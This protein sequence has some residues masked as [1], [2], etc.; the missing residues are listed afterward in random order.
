MIL[1]PLATTADGYK[2]PRIFLFH[3]IDKLTVRAKLSSVICEFIFY[4]FPGKS[5]IFLKSYKWYQVITMIVR[6][7]M[8]P[9]LECTSLYAFLLYMTML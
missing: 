7:V 5:N 3:P 6:L 2:L 9:S 1:R 4:I 8:C